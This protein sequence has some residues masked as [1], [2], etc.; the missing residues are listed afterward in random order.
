M[1]RMQLQLGTLKDFDFGRAEAAFN[2]ALEQVVS[3]MMKRPGISDVREVHLAAKFKPPLVVDEDRD[4]LEVE[5]VFHVKPKVPGFRTPSKPLAVNRQGQ[6]GFQTDAPD[7]PN[8]TTL[9]QEDRP[10]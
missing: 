8:Q 9:L 10:E 4:L 3:D 6:L 2:H 1:P 7:N 5:V